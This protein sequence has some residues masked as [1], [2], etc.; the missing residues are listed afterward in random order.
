MTRHIIASVIAVIALLLSVSCQRERDTIPTDNGIYP[1]N[2]SVRNQDYTEELVLDS[3]GEVV[4]SSVEGLPSWVSS[5][6]LSPELAKGNSV[7]LIGIKRNPGLEAN[8]EADVTLK[9]TNGATATFHIVQWPGRPVENAPVQSMNTAFEKDWAS[10]KT[11]M[12]VTENYFEN[13][14][15][16]VKTE[17]VRLPWADN[18]IHHLPYGEVSKMLQYKG[19][20][21]MVF[22][23]TG[24]ESLAG[25][26]F[27]GL[28]N[29]YTG[30]LRVFYYVVKEDVPSYANDHLW[31]FE[32]NRALAEHLAVQY[33][34]PYEVSVSSSFNTYASSPALMTPYANRADDLSGGK[35][36]PKVGWWAFDVDMSAARKDDFFTKTTPEFTARIE[37]KLYREDNVMLNSAITGKLDGALEGKI[38]LDQ[39]AP[40]ST[41]DTGTALSAIF[42]VAGGGLMSMFTLQSIA[43]D[44]KDGQHKPGGSFLAFLGAGLQVGGKL[45]ESQL[46]EKKVDDDLG[47]INASINLNLSASMVTEG[48]IGGECSSTVPPT[49][50]VMEDFRKETPDKKPTGFGE[51]VWNLRNHPVVY[52]VK[53][54]YWYERDF[55]GFE[56]KKLYKQG[57]RDIYSY[58]LGADADKPG[59]RIITFLD[60]TSVGGVYL[61][62]ALFDGVTSCNVKLTY[63][64]FPNAEDGYTEAYR[65]AAGLNTQK[66]WQ[67]SKLSSFNTK[68]S[69]KL[70]FKLVKR[71]KGDAM[72]KQVGDM[73]KELEAYVAYRRSEQSIRDKVIRRYYGPSVFYSLESATP[74]DVDQVH[75]VS[76][77]QIDV[78]IIEYSEVKDKKTTNYHYILDPQLPDFVVTAILNLRGKDNE[79]V[80][81]QILI[82]TLRFAPEIKFI[83]YKD[84]PK[85]LQTIENA[86]MTNKTGNRTIPVDWTFM[87]EQIDKIRQFN[88]ALLP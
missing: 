35:Y 44:P 55:M 14:R 8:L 46:K 65:K 29:R 56:S 45:W 49:S 27:F 40:K 19:D 26:H 7:A 5:V 15:A 87:D 60:P 57:D 73:D 1:F 21:R 41:T 66:S 31:C 22:N 82:H 76:D 84:L 42:G 20:W 54:A 39:L 28:Y 77:P 70:D 63:G 69:S 86:K 33:A 4:I 37:Q 79:D 52:V 36:I 51:G 71:K 50:L 32:L 12:L 34:L 47:D 43:G 24:V 61:N 25:S 80:D 13:G 10:A 58:R 30:F 62:D 83:S 88:A 53:D 81:E 17:E 75:F 23:V 2:F 78:P 38:N 68:E 11:I 48:V 72:F 85:V 74:Y 16:K 9:M 64:V 59:M 3:M 67:L 6:T 18:S